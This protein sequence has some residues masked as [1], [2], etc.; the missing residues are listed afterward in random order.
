MLI[1]FLLLRNI[2]NPVLSNF[3]IFEDDSPKSDG[4]DFFQEVFESTKKAITK[5]NV[6]QGRKKRQEAFEEVVSLAQCQV[7]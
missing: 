1:F 5:E 7:S 6:E 3:L 2:L 4:K